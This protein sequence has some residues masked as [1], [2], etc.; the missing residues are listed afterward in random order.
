MCTPGEAPGDARVMTVL[1]TG[2]A[3]FVGT[4]LCAD[5]RAAG[6]LVRPA[7]RHG[8]GT[9]TPETDW[10]AHL[11]GSSHVVHLLARV[12]RR[13]EPPDAALYHRDNV[14]LTLNLARQAARSGVRRFVFL[15]SVK[16]FGDTS[17]PGRA[18]RETDP[19][20]PTDPYGHSKRDA[21]TALLALGRDTGMEVVMLR[22]P[23]VYGAGV[24]A[25][26]RTLLRAVELGLPL[27]LGAITNRR[28]L[29]GLGNLSDMIIRCLDH[30]AA[31]GESYFVADGAPLSTT[32]LLRAI[33]RALDAPSRLLAVPAPL[34]D[35]LLRALGRRDLAARLLGDLEVDI[36]KAR[37]HL[38]WVPP[39]SLEIG[40]SE[41]VA[42]YRAG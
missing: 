21:E 14:A 39:F 12:H 26:F 31:A 34:L 42:A 37:D 32:E 16:V 20:H 10:S 40:L 3:G 7:D 11:A 4:R 17:P 30:P 27:P 24:K 19:P 29:V 6:R 5:L 8:V 18:W 1:V 38:G 22:P 9:V 36:A 23:M 41:A 33:A 25:N 13:G 28:S 15:S 35:G 2:A